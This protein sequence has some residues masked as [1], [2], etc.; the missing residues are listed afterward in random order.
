M[1]LSSFMSQICLRTLIWLLAVST[2]ICSSRDGSVLVKSSI[3]NLQQETGQFVKPL[4][5]L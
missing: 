4:I 5:D 3:V 2:S 1:Q